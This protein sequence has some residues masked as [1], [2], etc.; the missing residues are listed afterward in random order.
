MC[1]EIF[2]P[3]STGRCG[4]RRYVCMCVSAIFLFGRIENVEW[5]VKLKKYEKQKN[6]FN[7][8]KILKKIG[9]SPNLLVVA[10]DTI[11]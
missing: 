6:K 2:L 10:S 7:Y 3:T 4:R 5:I 11:S 9:I 1:D 8:K